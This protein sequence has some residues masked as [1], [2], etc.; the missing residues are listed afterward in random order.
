[1][2]WIHVSFINS[3]YYEQESILSGYNDKQ[4]TVNKPDP[5][6]HLFQHAVDA[7][8]KSNP[9]S[10]TTCK[11]HM[12]IIKINVMHLNSHRQ[13][14]LTRQPGQS[15]GGGGRRW[16]DSPW[17]MPGTTACPA[18]WHW[19]HCLLQTAVGTCSRCGILALSLSEKWDRL[20]SMDW[21]CPTFFKKKRKF[22][23]N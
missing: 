1:M 19:T 11:C 17:Q 8:T 5:L 7:V 16:W 13:D 15:P 6:S 10:P 22:I 14:D 4:L 12:K 21:T 2:A 18:Y 3:K 20:F 9:E 23:V